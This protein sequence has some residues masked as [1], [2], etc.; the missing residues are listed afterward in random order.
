MPS[1]QTTLNGIL[2]IGTIAQN[3]MPPVRNRVDHRTSRGSAGAGG[4]DVK[5]EGRLEA[6]LGRR[7]SEV[8]QRRP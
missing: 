1:R 3:V 4:D 7:L 5:G 6:G 8:L 2:R